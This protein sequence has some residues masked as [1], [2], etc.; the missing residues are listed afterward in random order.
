MNG[1]VFGAVRPAVDPAEGGVLAFAAVDRDADACAGGASGLPVHGLPYPPYTVKA[2]APA[3][4]GKPKYPATV[5]MTMAQAAPRS[6][7]P[8][9]SAAMEATR[10]RLKARYEMGAPN[11]AAVTLAAR[12]DLRMDVA[13]VRLTAAAR[14]VTA[15]LMD[16]DIV[17]IPRAFYDD[18]NERDLPAPDPVRETTRHVWIDPADP[19]FQE[20]V[21]DA[22]FYA[23]PDGPD[24]VPHLKRAAKAMLRSIED[25]EQL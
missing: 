3:V 22:E 13:P 15:R 11:R 9:E 18:H 17:R 19:D 8:H 25:G 7:T 6:F 24:L 10:R 5:Y 16:C 12:H 1:A 23:D 2:V 14:A 20:L 21:D 4:Y